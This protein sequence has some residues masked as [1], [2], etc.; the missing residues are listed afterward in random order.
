MKESVESNSKQNIV[1]SLGFIIGQGLKWHPDNFK[2]ISFPCPLYASPNAR[3]G[4]AAKHGKAIA[5]IGE[6]VHPEHIEKAHKEIAE[7]LLAN[8]GGRQ[9]EI[10]KL[11]GRFVIISDSKEEG[12]LLQADAIGLRSLYYCNT[13]D[14]TIAGAHAQMVS[15]AANGGNVEEQEREY[16]LGYPG[17][18]TRFVGVYRM[19]PN[20][21]LS[22]KTGTLK[23]F[24]PIEPIEESTIE[25]SWDFAFSEAH[26]VVE[27][28]TRRT[29]VLV[30]LTAG[31]DSRS[32]LA[33]ARGLWDKLSFFTYTN[34]AHPKHRLDSRVAQDI[35]A[36]LKLKHQLIAY[37]WYKA[38]P[39]LMAAV[40]SN[41]FCHHQHILACAYY[42]TFGP[43]HYVHI[44]TNLMELA[45]SNLFSHYS[46]KKGFALGPNT[47]NRMA[48]FYSIAGNVPFSDSLRDSFLKQ[49]QDA[50]METAL[51]FASPW[52]LFFIEH[53]MGAWQTGVVT[54]SDIAFD[55]VI[56]FNSRRIVKKFMGVPQEIRAESNYLQGK[57][58]ELIPEIAE[59][60]INPP[61]YTRAH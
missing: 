60:P 6:L 22:L 7:L 30:S 15:Q 11:I 48:L 3:I 45:R 4:V 38:D 25:D 43:Q 27:S 13:P 47:P 51:Q 20:N 50:D 53:R 24:F 31:L 26:K 44:R 5:V 57:I 37:K 28:L 16:S 33:A 52:D 17:I 34:G 42:D 8:W 2:K 21:S 35:A 40:Q 49:Y 9:A 32:T 46:K 61:T 18:D 56:A 10:D 19:P 12:T 55:T 29:P 36:V 58:R 39:D 1:Y 23:R 59:I 41:T 54:E 14:G